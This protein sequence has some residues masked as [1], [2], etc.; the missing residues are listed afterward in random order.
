MKSLIL[1]YVYF[2]ANGDIKAITPNLDEY[3]ASTCSFATFPVDEVTGFLTAQK[4]PYDYL[5][6]TIKKAG[7]VT[8]R[9]ARKE[10][11]I[12]YTRTLDNYLTKVEMAGKDEESIV[13]ITNNPKDRVIG[14]QIHK[15]FKNFLID[16]TEE[17]QAEAETFFNRQSITLYFTKKNDPYHWLQTI[18]F[19]PRNAYDNPKLYFNYETDLSD[20][21]VYTKKI[22]N[23]YAYRIE[24]N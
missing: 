1:M 23:S 11:K 9:I 18:T 15:A 19:S 21:S 16:G 14:I 13:L 12:N 22:V 10:S 5:I 7:N 4:N 3:F 20:A 2:D 8:Y 24:R 17:E 6:K